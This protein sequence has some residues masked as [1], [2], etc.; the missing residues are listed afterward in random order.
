[1]T[2]STHVLTNCTSNANYCVI[3]NCLDFNGHVPKKVMTIQ[4]FA[5]ILK[6]LISLLV[7]DKDSE[8]KRWLENNCHKVRQLFWNWDYQFILLSIPSLLY[9]IDWKWY[10]KKPDTKTCLLTFNYRVFQLKIIKIK[11]LY[12]WNGA[13]LTPCW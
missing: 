1:M 6:I 5:S 9:L 12:H 10:E 4:I 2:S 7:H 11:W 3:S 8:W 13:Y